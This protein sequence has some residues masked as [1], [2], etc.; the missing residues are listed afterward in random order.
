MLLQPGDELVGDLAQA[1]AARVVVR[2]A[3][4]QV[5][6]AVP[7]AHVEVGAVAGQVGERL[8]HEGRDQAALLRQRL[9]HV[10][11]EDRAVAGRERVGEVEVL[12]ELPVGVL[13]V[14]RVHRPSRAS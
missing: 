8:R 10:A 5:R 13:V 2:V 6:L 12:L 7:E 3:H 1:E 4:E 9:D 11:V 14:G